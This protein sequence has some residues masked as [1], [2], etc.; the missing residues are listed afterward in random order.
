VIRRKIKVSRK[1]VAKLLNATSIGYGQWKARPGD[2]IVFKEWYTNNEY[3]YRL[4][5]LIGVITESDVVEGHSA[6]GELSVLSINDSIHYGYERFVKCEDVVECYRPE[7]AR[8][9]MTWLLNASVEELEKYVR[10]DLETRKKAT[11]YRPE[12]T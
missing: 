2:I 12:K 9:F 5:R 3:R 4:A 8:T 6:A 10:E 1:K 11:Y 7:H